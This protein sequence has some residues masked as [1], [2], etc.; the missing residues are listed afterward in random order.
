MRKRIAGAALVA[1]MAAAAAPAIAEQ[2]TFMTGPQGGSW[3]PLG[4][5]LKNM[6]E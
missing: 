1:C 3:I 5:A 4:G 6:W 2:I